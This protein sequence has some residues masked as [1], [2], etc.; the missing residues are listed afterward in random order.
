MSTEFVPPTPAEIAAKNRAVRKA[1]RK[2]KRQPVHKILDAETIYGVDSPQYRKAE[3]RYGSKVTD[4][5]RGWADAGARKSLPLEMVS[6]DPERF[7][8]WKRGFEAYRPQVYRDGRYI[9]G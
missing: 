9:Q 1:I 7:A 8:E 5:E 4:Y 6:A 3:A 2:L